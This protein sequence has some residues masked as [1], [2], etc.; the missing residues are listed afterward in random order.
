M[1]HARLAPRMS[2]AGSSPTAEISNKVRAL[3]AQ[4]HKV[5]NLGEG[6][7]DFP[8]PPAIC[9]AGIAAIRE[10]DTKYTAVP[11]T[12]ELK[13]AIR[14]KFARE[15]GLAYAA[16]EVIAGAGAKQL[17]FNAFL[18]TLAP[19]DEVIVPAPYWVSYPDM[20][21]L[22][23]GTPVIVAATAQEG[24]KLTPQKL[25]AAL[26][27]RTRWVVLNS[28]NNPSGAVYSPAE[29]EA[30]TDVLLAHPDVLVM[31]D[32]IYEHVRFDCDF[33]TPAQVEPHLFGRTLTV[34]GLSKGYSMTGWRIGYAGGPA[35]LVG[36]MQVLQSQSTSN[37][38][39]ISQRAAIAALD[40][41]LD[42]MTGW[43]DVLRERRGVV[44][45]MVARTP[46]LSAD[47]PDGAFY[48]FADCRGLIGARTPDGRA[49]AGDLDVATY[50]LDA[51]HVGVVHGSAFGTPGHIRIA[52]AVD[53]DV[54]RAA[55]A[56]IEAAC[57][58]LMR[59]AA[60]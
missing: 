27:P 21:R 20:V 38:S 23:E 30:L 4:G 48:V 50:L 41:G 35:W 1:S 49:I 34:N 51:A 7:L 26:T 5:V 15:N 57:H 8:T 55:C 53:T 52:Y 11:G 56:R 6:E 31:A 13:R 36:A 32:D 45:D 25:A 24:W 39:T 3:V 59:K 29:M 37:P 16:D 14:A 58:A 43:L 10:G 40:G 18:A 60:A 17:I 9:E 46:G 22:A 12:A 42:F 47:V 28:P 54:L 33:A 19:G 44:L 2:G